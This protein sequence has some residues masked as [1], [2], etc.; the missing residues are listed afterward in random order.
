M[1]Q[2]TWGRWGMAV[3]GAAPVWACA[4]SGPAPTWFAMLPDVLCGLAALVL[5][6][7][8]LWMLYLA[9]V[10]A[11]AGEFSFRRHAGSFGG[12]STGWQLSQALARLVSGLALVLL[13]LALT[14]A[15]SPV[16]DDA[17][18]DVAPGEA[19]PAS[20]AASAAPAAS[21][22]SAAASAK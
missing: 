6:G 7:F 22:P 19:K 2:R 15:R 11:D 17:R 13:A 3:G 8:G 1:R 9:L 4:A 12:S 5:V 10:R 14:M 20:A 21:A 16:K 18:A